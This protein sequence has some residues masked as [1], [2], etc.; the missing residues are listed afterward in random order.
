MVG[1]NR[2]GKLV[3]QM[4]RWGVRVMLILNV[5]FLILDWKGASDE[6]WILAGVGMGAPY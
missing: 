6:A 2:L 1:E 5:E 3:L 4:G